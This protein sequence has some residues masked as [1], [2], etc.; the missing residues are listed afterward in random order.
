MEIRLRDTL[1]SSIAYT[2]LSRCGADMETWAEELL[3]SV[4]DYQVFLEALWDASPV[5]V[6]IQE[7]DGEAKGYFSPKEQKIAIQPGMSESQTVKTAVHEIAHSLAV[8]C[9]SSKVAGSGN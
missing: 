8:R 3:Q 5:P 6:E 1:S 7:I 9:R 4:D 2:L